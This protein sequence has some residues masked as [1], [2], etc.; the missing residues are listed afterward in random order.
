MTVLPQHCHLF[1]FS[2]QAN[3]DFTGFSYTKLF[4]IVSQIFGI[5]FMSVLVFFKS[6]RESWYFDFIKQLRWLGSVHKFE[7]AFYVVVSILVPFSWCLWP[8]F[9]LWLGYPIIHFLTSVV[10]YRVIP[11]NVVC[12]PWIRRFMK[13][14]MVSLLPRS[15][16]SMISTEFFLSSGPHSWGFICI[17]LPHTSCNCI[18]IRG[19]RVPFPRSFRHLSSLLFLL[20]LFLPWGREIR[21]EAI[22]FFSLRGFSFRVRGSSLRVRRPPTCIPQTRSGKISTSSFSILT[23]SQF[24]ISGYTESRLGATK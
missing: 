2:S 21:E 22:Y 3:R 20:P 7:Q 19:P 5:L 16:L 15:S 13:N 23:N 4:C 14:F 17:I 6:Y 1:I 24:S 9:S 12:G 10:C 11:M 18:H 8:I